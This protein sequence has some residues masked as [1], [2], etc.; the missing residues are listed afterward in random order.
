MMQTASQRR[1][2]VSPAGWVLLAAGLVFVL[3]YGL[4]YRA[5]VEPQ[6]DFGREVHVAERVAEG[7]VLYQD[8][9]FF[10]GPLSALVNGG[11][12]HVAGS[13]LTTLFAANLLVLLLILICSFGVLRR[14]SD[15][16]TAAVAILF[17]VLF[18]PFGFYSGYNIYTYM[19]PYSHEMTHGLLVSWLLLWLLGLATSRG[20]PW[21]WA[22]AGVLLAVLFLL[23]PEFFLA[24]ALVCAGAL[25][26][27]ARVRGFSVACRNASG[28]LSAGILL[29]VLSLALVFTLFYG[30]DFVLHAFWDPWMYVFN[31]RVRA[32]P[33][34]RVLSGWG[35]PLDSLRQAFLAALG[36]GFVFGLPWL[37]FR[38]SSSRSYGLLAGGAALAVSLFWSF[39]L[40]PGMLTLPPRGLS[41]LMLALVGTQIWRLIRKPDSSSIPF[42]LL[43]LFALG[44]LSKI[45]LKSSIHNYGFVLGMPAFMVFVL[46]VFHRL[47]MSVSLSASR[48]VL[49]GLYA[50]CIALYLLP[51][52]GLSLERIH[53]QQIQMGQGGDAVRVGHRG[54]VMQE[55]VEWLRTQ[56][57]V[58]ATVLPIPDGLL[59]NHFA[60]RKNPTSLLNLL[61]PE[62]IM[63]GSDYI[64][65]ELETH[66]PDYI[67]LVHR[68]MVEYGYPF[69]GQGFGSEVLESVLARYEPVYLAGEFPMQKEHQFGVLIM[70]RKA[71][72]SL[73][74]TDSR[75]PTA[76]GNP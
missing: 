72:P 55:A 61:P 12:F 76:G 25:F 49:Q 67:L 66:P 13:S 18:F 45:L 52:V 53:Q 34:Y 63:W 22:G 69:F 41:L 31:E 57:P 70:H 14:A 27:E 3:L 64:L 5:W 15:A 35:Q 37:A 26:A 42:F 9:S 65:T 2:R 23:K 48:F 33:F 19:A 10:N 56:T 75:T 54:E 73:A 24:G 28:L 4:T 1:K 8:I 51:Q 68:P 44:L 59:I 7:D 21:A 16:L 29:G 6:V 62:W 39:W 32:L 17:F 36:L 11:L 60:G 47:P 74:P 30:P 58:E 40:P 38:S 71:S 43:A 20:I 50:V 46:F